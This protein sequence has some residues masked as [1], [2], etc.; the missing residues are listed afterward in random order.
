MER[1]DT[2]MSL[3]QNEAAAASLEP[4]DESV[5]EKR[6]ARL[7][8]V[9]TGQA[10][11]KTLL[12]LMTFHLANEYYGVAVGLLQEVQP[13]DAQACSLVPG[14][15]DFIVGAVNIRGRIYSVMDV[16]RYLGLPSRPVS[17]T[18]HLLRVR[19]QSN[20]AGG[21]MEL[22]ILTDDVPAIAAVPEA[23]IQSPRET[24]SIRA[25]EYILGVQGD[26]L[27]IL[28]LARLLADPGIIVNAAV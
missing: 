27:V 18:A 22:C 2:P 3:Q 16:A 10:A 23:D 13:F 28:D 5:L 12:R 8:R 11:E 1:K 24:L 9:Q 20:S 21:D 26:M 25:R 4:P 6:A 15:P 19:G 14:T 7:A 17:K